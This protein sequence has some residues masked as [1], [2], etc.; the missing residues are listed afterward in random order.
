M[1]ENRAPGPLLFWLLVSISSFPAFSQ[2]NMLSNGNFTSNITGWTTTYT[3]PGV[4]STTWDG[5]SPCMAKIVITSAGTQRWHQK[6]AQGVTLTPGKSYSWEF[7]AKAAAN[8]TV[9]FVI[10]RKDGDYFKSVDLPKSLTTTLQPFSGTFTHNPPNPTTT[11]TTFNFSF[12]SGL[13]TGTYYV[14]DCAIYLLQPITASAGTNGTISPAGV[15]NVKNGLNQTFTMTPNSGYVVDAV[16]VDGVSQGSSTSYTFNGVVAPHTISVTFKSATTNYTLSTVVSPPEAGEITLDPT[17]GTY[18]AGASVTATASTNTGFVFAGWS[19]ASTSTSNPVIIIVDANKTLYANCSTAPVYA[20]STSTTGSGSGSIGLNPTGGSYTAGKVVTLTAT[21]AASSTFTGWTGALTGSINPTTITMD[22]PKSVAATFTLKTNPISA[23]AGAGGT[24]SPAGITNVNYGANQSYVIAP[25]AGF[26]IAGVLVDGVSVGAVSSYSFNNVITAHNIAASFSTT[27]FAITTNA[28]A[29]GTVTPVNPTVN[30]GANKDITVSANTGFVIASVTVDGVAIPAAVGVA[31]YVKTFTNV[32][33][34]HTID[35]TFKVNT[36]EYTLTATAGA[37]GAISP[38][39]A[40]SVSQGANQ[41]FSII[42]N[43][44]YFVDQVNVDGVD[45]GV[46][47]SYTFTNVTAD[48]TI[49]ATFTQ[50]LKLNGVILTSDG[51]VGIGVATVPTEELEVIGT[52]KATKIQAT[53]VVVTPKWKIEPPDYVFNPGYEL[54]SL[55]EMENFIQENRHLKNLPSGND[56]K[57]R[58]IDIAQMNMDLLK[59]IEELTLHTISLNRKITEQGER[60]NKLEK[61]IEARNE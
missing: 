43:T 28:G 26:Q 42:P 27:T 31:S 18:V 46:L 9:D 4:S 22:A 24:I 55:E 56:L 7:K 50:D 29:N 16:T 41:T 59:T 19:G 14:D 48:H 57:S 17:G 11:S 40:V 38:P 45:L 34:A 20:L 58:G 49:N 1:S 61:S 3:S 32:I 52:I 44:G 5:A 39:G 60:I 36:I 2:T 51:K 54:A 53:E 23:T 21:P 25:T 6:F 12:F 37:G 13:S 33:A 47:T 35:A 10:E 15:V 8:R 30:Y